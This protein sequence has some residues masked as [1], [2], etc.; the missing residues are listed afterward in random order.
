MVKRL[1]STADWSAGLLLTVTLRLRNTQTGNGVGLAPTPVSRSHQPSTYLS[2]LFFS[3][4]LQKI[5]FKFKA[6][7]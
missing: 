1:R 7:E 3:L 6:W 5:T 2:Y 4:I